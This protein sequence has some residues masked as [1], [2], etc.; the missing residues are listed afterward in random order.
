MTLNYL[1]ISRRDL[2][3]LVWSKPMVELAKGFG[4]SDVALAKRCRAVSVPVP[5]RGYWARVAAGQKP[6]R[7]PF[8]ATRTRDPDVAEPMVDIPRRENPPALPV[9]L[10]LAELPSAISGSPGPIDS[11]LPAVKRSARW[12]KHPERS[13]LTFERGTAQGPVVNI[14]VSE[15]LLD[16]ALGFADT[17]LRAADRQGWV[18][19]SPPP[20]ATRPHG[21]SR[22]PEP[23][24]APAPDFGSIRI[25]EDLVGFEIEERFEVH[26]LP[27]TDRDVARQAKNP[28]HRPAVRTETIHTGVLRLTRPALPYFCHVQRKTWFDRGQHLLE[29][30]LEAILQDFAQAAAV[31]KARR[32]QE[33]REE[34]AR[35]EAERLREQE[36][37]R[38]AANSNMIAELER[39]AGAWEYARR[40]RRYVRAARRAVGTRQF[41][42]PPGEPPIDFIA[43]AERYVE[44]L[45]PLQ[46]V[47]LHPDRTPERPGYGGIPEE[48]V[49]KVLG[50]WLNR[51]EFEPHKPVLE[52]TLPG[53]L[54]QTTP[55]EA[56]DDETEGDE[57]ED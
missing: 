9:P 51:D 50:R 26:V 35:E 37:K 4:V 34:R 21:Y 25:G 38:R 31:L 6:H 16:R 2:Y 44:E 22:E 12:L 3:D 40:L 13:T 57:W 56:D 54:Q 42:W 24:A 32:E 7:L 27:P 39:Q 46:P 18:F 10:P 1:T 36:A 52:A 33:E 23:A 49:R 47:A 43:W 29:S 17:L 48:S 55:D 28:W 30:K 19:V 41:L 45:D 53:E 11:L 8:P 5:P 20:R 14:R 15:K